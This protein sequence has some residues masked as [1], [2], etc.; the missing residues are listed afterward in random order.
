MSIFCLFQKALYKFCTSVA[1]CLVRIETRGRSNIPAAGKFILVSNHRSIWDPLII[2]V[3]AARPVVWFA[4]SFLRQVP[5]LGRISRILG[6]KYIDLAKRSDFDAIHMMEDHIGNEAVVGI[7]PEGAGRLIECRENLGLMPFMKGFSYFAVKKRVPVLPACI[8]PLR[9]RTK[10]YPVS[11]SV[12][13]MILG[14]KAFDCAE[15]RIVYKEVVVHFLPL[16]WPPEGENQRRAVDAFV[17]EV[18]RRIEEVIDG[19]VERGEVPGRL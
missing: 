10:G 8:I 6:T 14:K 9:E 15:K 13:R 19:Y 17:K 4:A 1:K 16:M 3:A 12:R 7:F 5:I 11:R 2:M 18:Q